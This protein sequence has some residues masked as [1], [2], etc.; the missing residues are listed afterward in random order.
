[1]G[2][3]RVE[4]LANT[5]AGFS[6]SGVQLVSYV[7]NHFRPAGFSDDPGIY[8]LVPKLMRHYH[9]SADWAFGIFT[10]VVADTSFILG[11][12]AVFWLFKSWP[13]RLI[14]WLLLYRLYQLTFAAGDVYVVLAGVVVAVLPWLLY[15]TGQRK[16]SRW[17][18]VFLVIAGV[19]TGLGHYLRTQAELPIIIFVVIAVALAA[20]YPWRLKFRSYGLFA[21]GLIIPVLLFT[22]LDYQRDQFLKKNDPTYQATSISHPFW[23]P[24]YL[25]LGF[26]DNPYGI[27]WDD[28]V[29]F[30]KVKSIDPTATYLSPRYN[31]IL[32][33]ESLALIRHHPGYVA[34]NYW[35]KLKII[36]G[37]L[38]YYAGTGLIISLYF[39]PNRNLSIAFWLALMASALPAIIA[40]PGPSYL[41]GFTALA[42]IW[43]IF[44]LGRMVDQL[45][46]RYRAD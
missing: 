44:N 2:S 40:I 22:K 45:A 25:G 7:D 42:V 14:G 4:E 27:R 41:L 11:G 26:I 29:A 28:S 46:Q 18:Q 9:W 34:R 3:F 24:F 5:A 19:I 13:A 37:Y 20:D 38:L 21:L 35:A 15:F 1:M 12:L 17:Y 10:Q 31:Q 36:I 33:Q 6:R 30:D 23:H 39:R 43:A 32:K 8:Y 16:F